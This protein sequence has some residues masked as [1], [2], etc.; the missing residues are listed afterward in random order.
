L[1]FAEPPVMRHWL[2]LA[3]A[4]GLVPIAAAQTLVPARMDDPPL[5]VPVPRMAAAPTVDGDLADWPA[6]G[7]VT[8]PVRPAVENDDRNRAGNLDVELRAGHHDGRVYLAARWPDPRPDTVFKSWR[9]SGSRYR[10]GKE[11][12][13][14][15]AVRFD[16]GGDYDSCMLS[17]REYRVDVWLWSAGRSDPA[18]YA[19]DTWQLMTTRYLEQAAEYEAPSGA[20][21]YIRKSRDEGSPIYVNTRPDRKTYAGDKLPGIEQTGNPSG[22]VADVRAKGRWADG[23][24]QLEMSRALDT[25]HADDAALVPGKVHRGAIAVFERGYSEHKSAS[26]ELHFELAPN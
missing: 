26:G 17:D 8:V 21:V 16:L 10:R 22:S 15:F 19:D 5:T 23:H 25:G 9:W 7:W 11:Y 18:G 20:T 6:G 1:S 24:W 3:V 2:V 13:D 14:M 4:T 12:D